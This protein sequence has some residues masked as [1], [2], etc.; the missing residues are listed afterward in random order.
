MA[1]T[2]FDS[3]ISQDQAKITAIV[4][5]VKEHL[6]ND[7]VVDLDLL[8][9]TL[10]QLN[11][12]KRM[13]REKIKEKTLKEMNEQK[14]RLIEIGRAYIST[15]KEGDLITF[16]YGPANFQKQATLPIDKK[17]PATVQVT[18]PPEMLGAGSKTP[19][20][21]IHY[22]KIIVPQEFVE[23]FQQQKTSLKSAS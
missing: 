5:S 6:S 16:I 13:V 4:S 22:D 2:F 12:V 3:L 15:L 9:A 23:E 17:G 19:K 7:G 1:N 11:E 14:D 20:R 10:E 18:Y 21:N 8:M